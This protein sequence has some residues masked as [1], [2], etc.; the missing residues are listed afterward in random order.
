MVACGHVEKRHRP[1]GTA[2]YHITDKGKRERAQWHE[3]A[4]NA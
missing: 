1:D 3:V 2:E 4:G